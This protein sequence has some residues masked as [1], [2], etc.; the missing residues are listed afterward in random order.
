M[1][2]VIEIDANGEHDDKDFLGKMLMEFGLDVLKQFGNE[3]HPL[4]TSTFS[5]HCGVGNREPHKMYGYL[6]TEYAEGEGPNKDQAKV[7]MRAAFV[8]GDI[9]P[10]MYTNEVD[11]G[12]AKLRVIER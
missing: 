8:E 10:K 9:D 4:C 1:K 7:M 5:E 12:K 11:L 6:V 3:C 2:L